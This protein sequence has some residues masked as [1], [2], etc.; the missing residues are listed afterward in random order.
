[1]NSMKRWQAVLLAL[2][3]CVVT[4]TSTA[5]ASESGFPAATTTTAPST[6]ITIDEGVTTTTLPAVA[7][8]ETYSSIT[9]DRSET[10][11]TTTTTT[12]TT[13]L[14]GNKPTTADTIPAYSDKAYVALNNN[15]P[16]FSADELTTTAYERYSA[17]DSLGRCGVAIAS[18]G[19]EIMPKDNEKRGDIGGI[20]PSGWVQAKYDTVSGGYL[21]NRSHLIGW[22]LSAENA[23]KQNL[24]TG[25]RY[26]NTEGMLPFENMVADYILETGNHV[27][28]RITPIYEGNDL[29]ASGVQMEAYSI[30]DDGE[31]ICFNVYVYNVQPGIVIDYATGASSSAGTTTTATTT[32]K[33]TTTTMAATTTT[34]KTTTTTTKVEALVWIPQSGTKYHKHEGCSNMK[35]PSQVSQSEAENRGYTPCKKCY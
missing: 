8:T 12:A 5:C 13:K 31:G 21:Y 17:L 3:L 4:L 22:Q 32:K 19:K 1:M 28:Y 29:L 35:N 23:N 9:D 25:T 2:V 27:A 7:T 20:T 30:E 26:M 14:Q 18:C 16:S 24:I 11:E 34:T 15:V 6:V 10:N 33:T